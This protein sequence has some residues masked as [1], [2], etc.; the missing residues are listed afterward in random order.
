MQVPGI[1]PGPVDTGRFSLWEPLS[2]SSR[3]WPGLGSTQHVSSTLEAFIRTNVNWIN[4]NPGSMTHTHQGSMHG[5]F[6]KIFLKGYHFFIF[7]LF[8]IFGCVGVFIAACGLSAVV[9]SGGYS[10]LRCAGFSLQWLLLL[11]STGSRRTGFSSC[12]TWAQQLRHTGP[13]V[14]R[15]Q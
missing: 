14:C 5:L 7:Y 13:R 9:A 1:Q 15:L 12:S 8:F 2:L 3:L 11:R 6:K 4:H 10:L